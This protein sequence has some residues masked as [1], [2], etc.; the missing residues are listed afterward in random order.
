MNEINE[1]FKLRNLLEY[2]LTTQEFDILTNVREEEITPEMSMLHMAP[3]LL[4]GRQTLFKTRFGVFG[5]PRTDGIDV[6][7]S[8]SG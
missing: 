1:S 4:Y 3:T 8:L 5:Y 6:S 7:S 2:K